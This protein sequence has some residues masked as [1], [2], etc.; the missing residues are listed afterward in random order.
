MN[1]KEFFTNLAPG[2]FR[3][4]AGAVKLLSG[5]SEYTGTWD[6]PQITHLLRRT[7]FGAKKSDIAHLATMTMS[8]AVDY[9]L[10]VPP[11]LPSPPINNYGSTVSDPAV[12]VGQT[13]VNAP[14]DLNNIDGNVANARVAS[15]RAWWIGQMINDGPNIREKMT[16]FWHNHFAT[17][18]NVVPIGQA[19]HKHYSTLRENSL[20]NFKALAKKITLDSTMLVYLNGYLNTSTAPDE[21][22]AR[23]LQ[24]LFTVGKG[25]DSLY[26]EDDVKEAAKIL[27][28][29]T[30]NPSSP[31]EY[32]FVPFGRHDTS[33]KQFSSFYGN[34][35]IQGRIGAAG[36]QEL[37]DLL[38][39]IFDT[40][41]CAKHICRAFYRFFVYYKIDATVEA[42]VITPLAQVFRDS[43]YEIKPTL[44]VLFKSEHFFETLSLGCVIKNPLDFAV[45]LCR[46]FNV[47]IPGSGQYEQ[48]YNHWY[49]LYAHAATMNMNIGD[50]PVVSGWPAYYQQPMY[51]EIW[52][53]SDTIAKRI[54]FADA[55]F[56]NGISQNGATLKVD[57]VAFASSMPNPADPNDLIADSV[58]Y[59]YGIPIGPNATTYLKSFLL[60]G[61]TQDYYWADAWTAYTQDPND[62]TN[63]NIVTTRLKAFY[64]Y[65]VQQAEYHLS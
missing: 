62:P 6:T 64:K 12:P 17:E 41:E 19:L 33:N 24:E 53:D 44:E 23:E 57:V 22:Y 18:A 42:N 29:F 40:E 15:L 54:S 45:G 14:V 38:D 35:T 20:G 43:G 21:N 5:L 30:I 58:K 10:T 16:I 36:E 50:P 13:W 2:A 61:Q 8:D 1:R 11:T 3:H 60:G 55:I 25:P 49:V 39:M 27:T 48:Q 28:G 46:E 7:G 37:D 47:A 56:D 59:L 65:M 4:N 31:L 9:I 51:H 52:I 32:L 34:R 26:T 63:L